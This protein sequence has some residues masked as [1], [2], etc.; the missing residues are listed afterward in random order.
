VYSLTNNFSNL[1]GMLDDIPPPKADFSAPP[2]YELATKLPSYEEAQQQ[3]MQELSRV[4]SSSTVKF[5]FNHANILQENGTSRNPNNP[6]PLT[7]F[8]TIDNDLSDCDTEASL[9]G[10]DFTFFTAFIGIISSGYFVR[11]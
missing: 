2:P 10:S 4:Q 1:K 7:A 5:S 11:I 6:Q 8:L 3:K 9:L